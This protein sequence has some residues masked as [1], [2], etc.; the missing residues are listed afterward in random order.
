[1][2]KPPP[3]ISAISNVGQLEAG[4]IIEFKYE[5]KS[6]KGLIFKWPGLAVIS[7]FEESNWSWNRLPWNDIT[8]IRKI[9]SVTLW[10]EVGKDAY[11][12]AR[13]AAK[14]YF[15]GKPKS[16]DD[17][18]EAGDII[19]F[20][21]QSTV[22]KGLVYSNKTND[23][24]ICSEFEHKGNCTRIL[25]QHQTISNVVKIA[26]VTNKVIMVKFDKAEKVFNELNVSNFK[27][28]TDKFVPVAGDVV[29]L[30]IDDDGSY[31][32]EP[33]KALIYLDRQ[34]KLCWSDGKSDY[35]FI[36]HEEMTFEF[37]Y[38]DSQMEHSMRDVDSYEFND[39][40]S[41][42]ECQAAWV[43]QFNVVV[44]TKIRITKKYRNGENGV[45]WYWDDCYNNTRKAKCADDHVI[46]KVIEINDDNGI[47]IECSEN[48]RYTFPSFCLEIVN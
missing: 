31:D 27:A 9:D 26:R 29:N 5:G 34:N 32:N 6:C 35:D 15:E 24:E 21:Y 8:D 2:S 38:H 13:V 44:G 39:P 25:L 42:S 33:F 30:T 3:L 37:L 28:E 20:M 47:T 12:H 10:E 45:D 14:E 4:D 16:K 22:Y 36:D 43:K 48:L 46:G 1:M 11:D 7:M 18:I 23:L 40:R 19:E 41:Y 17:T